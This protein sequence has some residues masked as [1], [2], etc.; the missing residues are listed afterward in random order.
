MYFRPT[1]Q[2][3]IIDL[4]MDNTLKSVNQG[5]YLQVM[6]VYICSVGL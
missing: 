2:S 4:I 6:V 3:I 5:A 1:S